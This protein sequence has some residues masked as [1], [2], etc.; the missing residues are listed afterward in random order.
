MAYG[1]F[2][3]LKI[4]TIAVKSLRHK[5]FNIAKNPKYDEYQRVFASL[6]YKVF[7]K[8]VLGGK[9]KNEV[10]CNE[11]LAEELSRPS[12]RKLEKRNVHLP[13]ID[14]IWGAGFKGFGF[15]YVLLIFIEICMGY[16]F[17]RYKMNSNY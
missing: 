8:K 4:I 11:E 1:D 2:K 14:N 6:L 5:A 17:K 3:D 9:V 12:I 7:D 15:F 16:S 13:F 10:I